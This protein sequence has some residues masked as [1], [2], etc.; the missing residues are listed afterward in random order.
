MV[1]FERS[2]R[3]SAAGDRTFAMVCAAAAAVT[4][5]VARSS[6]QAVAGVITGVGFI[7][8]GVVFHGEGGLITGITTAAFA[9]FRVSYLVT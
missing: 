9:A 3:G 1:G 2:V 5:V 7:G 4:A 6:P 8:A